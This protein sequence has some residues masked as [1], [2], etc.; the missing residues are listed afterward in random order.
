MSGASA[1]RKGNSAE[2]EVVHA[3]ERAGF[4]AMS[5]RAA[6]GGYQSGEDIV[7]NF[8]L[9]IEVKNQ[10][11]LDLAGWWA[12]AQEQAVDKLPVVIHKRVGKSQAEEWWA[13]MD[14]ATLIA[15][16][17]SLRGNDGA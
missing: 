9:S 4:R 17:N 6:R 2:V 11:R 3:L 12:Q 8:P 7:T 16:V 10:A 13:T 15:L 1:R 14:L 5:S